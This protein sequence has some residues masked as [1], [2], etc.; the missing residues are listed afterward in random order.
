MAPG[1]KPDLNTNNVSSGTDR[2]ASMLLIA[3]L[4]AIGGAVGF[5]RIG[6]TL[7]VEPDSASYIGA[8][9]IRSLGYP[10]FLYCLRSLGIPLE[11]V[12]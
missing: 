2:L 8:T 10:F 6:T 9:G 11:G 7:M 4:I 1:A 3:G 5:T 12:P